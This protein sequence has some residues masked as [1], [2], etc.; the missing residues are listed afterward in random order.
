MLRY[1]TRGEF[2][3]AQSWSAFDPG[4]ING[5]PIKG[6]KMGCIG[7]GYLYMAPYN[8]GRSFSGT[9]LRYKLP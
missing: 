9:T 7:G 1:D 2:T 4:P 5:M 8:D 3:A 6:Y